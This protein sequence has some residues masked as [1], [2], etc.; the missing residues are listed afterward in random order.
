MDHK[1]ET[2][3]RKDKQ[4]VLNVADLDIVRKDEAF[5]QRAVKALAKEQ[6]FESV[7]KFSENVSK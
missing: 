7:E 5:W 2:G 1:S 3:K 6:I 4:V